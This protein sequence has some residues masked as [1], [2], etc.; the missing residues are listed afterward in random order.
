MEPTCQ[1]IIFLLGANL[2]PTCFGGALG[3]LEWAPFP[4][5]FPQPVAMPVLGGTGRRE[6][7]GAVACQSRRTLDGKRGAS[8]G[9]VEARG[10]SKGGGD[11]ENAFRGGDVAESGGDAECFGRGE[12]DAEGLG[13]SAGGGRAS[14]S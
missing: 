9:V 7:G 10:A 13:T 4:P 8:K 14:W 2:P 1:V 3:I 5:K 11:A 12:G 6:E